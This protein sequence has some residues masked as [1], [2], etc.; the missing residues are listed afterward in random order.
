[1]VTIVLAARIV[2][3]DCVDPAAADKA[4]AAADKVNQARFEKALAKTKAKKVSLPERTWDEPGTRAGP[5]G[6]DGSIVDYGGAH[7]LLLG[8]GEQVCGYPMPTGPFREL[9]QR[10]T[11]IFQIARQRYFGTTRTLK[12]CACTAPD[13]SSAGPGC[14]A[15]PR[16]FGIGYEVPDGTSYGGELA[17][18]Y[19]EDVV[20]LEYGYTKTGRCP[21]EPPREQLPRSMP[22]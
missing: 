7:L 10:G 9:A 1:M 11:T 15:A 20:Q 12:V 4:V 19:V 18:T 5:M 17:V 8:T 22:P 3:A 6:K 16:P 13:S 21:P 2:R 14:G